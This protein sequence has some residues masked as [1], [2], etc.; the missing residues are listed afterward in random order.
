MGTPAFSLDLRQRAVDLFHAGAHTKKQIARL[1]NIGEGTLK[2]YLRQQRETNDLNPIKRQPR[3]SAACNNPIVH[4]T[5][6]ALVQENN[7][8][9]LAEYCDALEKRCGIRISVPSM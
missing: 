6:L 1:L 5:I 8:S 3:E 2:K 4:A 7:D 9:T